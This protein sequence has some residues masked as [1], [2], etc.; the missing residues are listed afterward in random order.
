MKLFTA[1]Q[2]IVTVGAFALHLED[3]YLGSSILSGGAP[4]FIIRGIPSLG[5]VEYRT[6]IPSFTVATGI[7]LPEGLEFGLGPNVI[8]G[9]KKGVNTSL[10]VAVGKSFTTV[11]SAFRSI[12]RLRRA[13]PAIGFR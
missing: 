7:R 3:Q 9:G 10:V 4:S 2:L 13:R 12:W 11:A 1:M 8:F 5:G 6:V